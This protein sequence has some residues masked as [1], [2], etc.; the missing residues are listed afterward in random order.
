MYKFTYSVILLS[1]VAAESCLAATK[2]SNDNT[3][4]LKV[5]SDSMLP[6][7]RRIGQRVGF[8][9]RVN[10]LPGYSPHIN[11]YRLALRFD[12]HSRA[13]SVQGVGF[14]PKSKKVEVSRHF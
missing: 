1:L 10:L 14:K 6:A 8:L 12:F 13:K 2:T 3:Q 5:F 9:G 4:N 7:S 11:A